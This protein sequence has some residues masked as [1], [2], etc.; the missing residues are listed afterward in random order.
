MSSIDERVVEMKFNN[1]QFQSGVK[2]TMGA[3]DKLKTSLNLDGAA[4]SMQDLSATAKNFSLAGL[5]SG[6]DTASL[7]FMALATIGITAL[8]NITNKAI[9]TGQQLVK[10]LTTDQITAGFAEYELKMGSIQTIMAGSGES[11]DTVN[12]KLQELN[13]YSDKT[14]YSFADMTSN[15][16]KFTNAGVS[17]DKSVAAIQGVANVAALS[18]ANSNEASRAMYN[19]AQSLSAG[20]VKLMDWKSIEL[21][22]MA[23]VEFKTELMESAVAAGT[24]TKD[25]DGLYKTLEGTPVSATKGFN[26]SLSEQ[27]LTADALTE[28]LGR[29]ADENTDIG[30]RATAAASDVKTF[31]HLL[32]TL[33]ESAGSGWATTSELIFGDFEEGKKLWTGLNNVIG[34]FINDSAEARNE[35]LRGWKELGGRT[36]LLEGLKNSWN[37]LMSVITP[38][39][40]AFREIFPKTTSEQL[41]N[42]TKSFRAF[43]EQL[44]ASKGTIENIK[45]TFK[46]LFAVFDIAW[47]VIKGLA[48]VFA[49][50]FGEIFK[51]SGSLLG[52][53]ASLGDFIVGIRDA[54]KNGEG[55]TNFFDILKTSIKTVAQIVENVTYAIG[56]FFSSFTDGAAGTAE[57][58][59]DRISARLSPLGALGDMIAKIWAGVF[60]GLKK[61]AEFMGPFATKAAELFSGIGDKIMESMQNIDYNAVLDTINTGLLAGLVLIFKKFFDGGMNVDVGGG[62]LSS[63]KDAFGG[64]TETMTAM[65]NN[66]KAET[67]LKIA[68][69]IALLTVSVVALSL[70]DS[71]KLTSSLTAITV[72]FTQLMGAMAIFEKIAGSKGFVKMPVIAGAMILLA[73]AVLIL[74]AAVRNL[75]GLSWEELL[76]GLL[77]V[78]AL[79][80]MISA[81]ANTLSGAGKRMVKAGIGMI[82]IAI[83]V[84]ILASAVRDFS[85]LSWGEM[86]KGLVGV[87]AVLAALT[88]FTKL[89]DMNKI[90]LASSAGLIL[91]AI[92]LKIMA[93]AVGDFAGMDWDTLGRGFAGMAASLLLIAGAMRLMP[94]NMLVSAAGLVV[95]AGALLILSQVLKSMAG[96]SWEEIARG[97]VTLA[98]GLLII[99][100]AMKA[101]TTAIFGA[102][103]LLVVSAAL[104]VLAP[105]LLSFGAM[106][107][108]EIVRGLTMLAG[109]FVLLGVA[110]LVLGPVIPVLLGLGLA[111]TL[112]GVGMLAAGVGLLAFSAGLTALSIAGA[113]GTMALVGIVT[114]LIGLIP[115]A[116]TAVAQGIIQFALVIAGAVPAFT[117]A[118]VAVL[119]SLINAINVMAPQIVSTLLRLVF[120]LVD[121]LVRSVPRLVE[122]GFKLLIGI[123]DGIARNIG[124]VIKSATDI[125]VN[126]IDGIAR[127]LPRIVQSGANL[128]ITFVESLA[129][130]IRR[131]SRRMENAG[132]DLAD[133]IIDGMVGGITRGISSVVNAVTDM[134]S[135]AL[136]AAKNFLGIN[137][138]SK[139]F[140]DEVGIESTEGVAG[141]FKDGTRTVERSAEDMAK[142]ALY[143]V[144]KS[145][146]DISKYASADMEM[147][148]T[149][150]P[151]LDLSAVETDAK[152]IGQMLGKPTVKADL[153]YDRASTIAENYRDI[154]TPSPEAT[155]AAAAQKAP[156]SFVQ[157]N[158]SPKALS[159]AEIYRQT[160][161]QIS[162]VKGGLP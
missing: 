42:L 113:A 35:L 45:S 145:L 5:T 136:N 110:G 124:M 122:A 144:K 30:R 90:G 33:R 114:A 61:V 8:S 92:A 139:A 98:G 11:L 75:S 57:G 107:W 149:I 154:R 156:V 69:A 146:S 83:A 36:D 44:T 32:D 6:L 157:N 77:G 70:I 67:L 111:V 13:N 131:N 60:A 50:L 48:G 43:T 31:T 125:I 121:A 140:H 23:T 132:K 56:R 63:I 22:N 9:A 15:I 86:V 120:L 130:A 117:A 78:A 34:G 68:G 52:M 64:L 116:F 21:A 102:A 160:R 17:L 1:G 84:K 46:G 150:R 115:M 10:S 65:Q 105:I 141:G 26:E 20:S 152:R 4:K 54:I 87:G 16:G 134:A 159:T 12:R 79:L 55:L 155:P 24:L 51:G 27:W 151:V 118:M 126:F 18:G 73:T 138:P 80:G 2:D 109:V 100:V 72:M 14:I 162:V 135:R 93:S 71:A 38:I 128:I 88:I 28:T 129:D 37:G 41:A 96:M 47:M 103:A 153:A 137:S 123:L 148:P 66:L 104:A 85:S 94:K 119:Q 143:T 58:T 25:A 29:Y 91:L 106:T 95:V 89:A 108:D 97:L 53:T 74:T 40:E 101:M 49:T 127:G 112:L 59:I 161:N 81:T 147:D 3:L 158:Y 142:T 133:A 76:K 99:A 62:F 82:A 39:K 7:K 19:F